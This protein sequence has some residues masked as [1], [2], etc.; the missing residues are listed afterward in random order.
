M[1]EARCSRRH[2]LGALAVLA[3][4]AWG[5]EPVLVMRPGAESAD[6][7]RNDYYWRLLEAAMAATRPRLGEYRMVEAEQMNGLRAVYQLKRGRLNVVARSTSDELEQSLLPIRIPLDKGLLGYRV[8]LI[9]RELQAKLDQVNSLAALQRYSI[10]QQ[11]SW[12]DV[13][14]LEK[15]GFKV[16]RGGDYEGLFGMLANGRFD[17]FSRSVAEASGELA[18]RQEKFANLAIERSLLLYYPLPRYL[19]VRRDAGGERLAARIGEGF[20]MMLKDGS[21][22]RLFDSYKA[23]ID[24]TLKLKER[25]LFRIP[26]PFLSAE[27]PLKRT[28]LWYDPT[29]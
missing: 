17:L 27:T 10:G 20:D 22:G 24:T 3:C 5:G 25:R 9:R 4:P 2:V 13:A 16:V 6:D 11:S 21:F 19:F 14:I 28:E 29:R 7:H 8:F 12:N 15:G 26:N 23:I 1:P 18:A